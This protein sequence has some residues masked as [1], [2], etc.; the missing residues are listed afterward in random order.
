MRDLRIVLCVAAALGAGACVASDG[1]DST[2]TV[3]NDSSY[4]IDELYVAEISDPS[5]GPNLVYNSLA[6]GEE[7]TIGVSCG[8]YDVLVVDET[9]V[10]CELANLDLC[11]D[12]GIWVITD[13][14]LD[15]CAFGP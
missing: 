3:A 6:P 5:W 15:V 4:W 9:G 7:T 8:T 11:F 12:D 13:F 2:L 14:T 1:P 10:E